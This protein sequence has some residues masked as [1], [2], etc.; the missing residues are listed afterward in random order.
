MN[1]SSKKAVYT[2]ITGKYDN[3]ARHLYVREGWDYLCFT[4]NKNLLSKGNDGQWRFL[5]L[6]CNLSDKVKTARFHKINFTKVLPEYDESLWVDANISILTPYIFEKI[7]GRSL[8]VP[9]H[10]DRDCVFQEAEA[11]L[12]Y[13]KDTE[14]VVQAQTAFLHAEN[15]PEHYGLCETGIIY[16]RHDDERN[17]EVMDLW[18]K[19]VERFSKR[20]QLSFTYALFKNGGLH[21]EIVIPCMSKDKNNFKI[22]MHSEGRL[23]YREKTGN[24]K[25]WHIG[26]LKITLKKRT[27]GKLG[28]FLYK[29]AVEPFVR[30]KN[31]RKKRRFLEIGPSEVRKSGFEGV[32]I[33]KTPSADYIADVAGGLPFKDAEFD[34]IYSSHFLEHIE[35]FKVDFVV[36]EMFRCL[37]KD[38]RVEIHVPDG[39][40]IAKAFA[41]AEKL[42]S[43]EYKN[44]SWCKFN[45]DKD[46]CV[47]ANGRIFA[48]GDGKVMKGHRNTHLS[49][50]SERY[51]FKILE[52]AGFSDIKLTKQN[53]D[54][55]WIDLGVVAVKK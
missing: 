8:A 44:D 9:L 12:H 13:K 25:I 14:D 49:L 24:K 28:T 27:Y 10:P 31:C 37:K 53:E 55:G 2:C 46:P 20:D 51:L 54:H 36:S 17:A 32:N 4:D 19:T 47:W 43:N 23:I 29:Y 7:A 34:F 22:S 1:H 21:K 52:K 18:W 50:F 41:D 39:L 3:P 33:V 40:K 48:Y 30:L 15:M 35:W 6:V 45:P 5:P 11:V 38:G 16:R 42:S 26:K